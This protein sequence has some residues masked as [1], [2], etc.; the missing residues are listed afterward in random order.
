MQ[1][2]RVKKAKLIDIG[3]M[4]KHLLCEL[5]YFISTNIDSVKRRDIAV[6]ERNVKHYERTEKHVW[7]E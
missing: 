6:A 5:K 2:M 1:F 3:L 7:N 4:K